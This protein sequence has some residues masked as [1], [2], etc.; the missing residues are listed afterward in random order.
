M[1]QLP[2]THRIDQGAE[3]AERAARARARVSRMADAAVAHNSR[4]QGNLPHVIGAVQ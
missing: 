3:A 1:P 4:K 2:R